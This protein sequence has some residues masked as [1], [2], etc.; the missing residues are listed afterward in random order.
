MKN[1]DF[2]D[3]MKK[4]E[5]AYTS[6]RV[7]HPDILC[8]RIDGKK[9]SKYTKGFIKPFD[10][11]I[12]DAMSATAL[13]LVE[14]TNATLSYTQSDEIT[15]IFVPTGNEHI[16][17]GKVSK[18]NSILASMATAY[19]NNYMHQHKYISSNELAF[20]DCRSWAVSSLSE[21]AN[22]LL[23]RIHDCRKNSVSCLYRWT[24]GHSR[25]K[26]K[27]QQEMIADLI[28]NFNT[29]WDD[30]LYNYKYGTIYKRVPTEVDTEYGP[31][32][33]TKIKQIDPTDFCIYSHKR[34]EEFIHMESEDENV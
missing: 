5:S 9:F 18:I 17:G 1:D 14:Q 8:V 7:N 11:R 26:N 3:R 4:L 22:T 20:F 33:R 23:W 27:N 6:M 13:Y 16:F 21:A 32:I 10:E 30:L 28:V 31:A 15:L 29:K 19:F 24:A 34:R 2:G 25:M 12:L